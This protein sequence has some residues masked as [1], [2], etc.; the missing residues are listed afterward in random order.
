[1]FVLRDPALDLLLHARGEAAAVASRFLA[2]AIPA[3]IAFAL[4]MALSG[5]LRAVGDA[6][7]AMYVTLAGRR[8]SP[9]SPIRC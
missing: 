9:P 3:N 2:I 7:R 4:G 6:R 5:V 1:M 8:R